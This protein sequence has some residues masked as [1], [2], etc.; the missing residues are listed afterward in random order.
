MAY[1]GTVARMSQIH[2]GGEPMG[3]W[4]ALPFLELP[5]LYTTSSF[6]FHFLVC[7]SIQV[8]PS[9]ITV[10]ERDLSSNPHPAMS[11]TK[12]QPSNHQFYHDIYPL[13]QVSVIKSNKK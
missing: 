3:F 7:I 12:E 13:T 11:S 9:T 6:T 8:N 2:H 1:R 4:K 5:L 10:R